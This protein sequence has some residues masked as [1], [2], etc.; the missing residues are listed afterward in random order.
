VGFRQTG[1]EYAREARH[2]GEAKYTLRKLFGLA[3]SGY[4]GFSAMP[5]RLATWLG[6]TAAGAGF[7]V[8]LWALITKVAGIPSPRGWASTVAL[9]L[10]IGG[11][12]LLMLG[13]IGEYLSRVYDEVRQ[14]PLYV[15]KERVGVGA[16]GRECQTTSG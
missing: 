11:T 1:V 7:L 2:A 8:G 5:L 16:P 3:L 15:V 4:L 10:F 12:Q 14:R 6:V 13:V 9:I